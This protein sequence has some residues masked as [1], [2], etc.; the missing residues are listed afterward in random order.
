MDRDETS[1]SNYGVRKRTTE[2]QVNASG[3]VI[4][5]GHSL[6][7]EN[8]ET[9]FLIGRNGA[10]LWAGDP[11]D[12]TLS[13]VIGARL[14]TEVEKQRTYDAWLQQRVNNKAEKAKDP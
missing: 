13:Q 8:G 10:I 1:M 7:G 3:A 2:W 14:K 12:D 5:Q 9:C 11:T 6:R 4:W